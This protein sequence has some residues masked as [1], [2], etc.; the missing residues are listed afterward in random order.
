MKLRISIL[1]AMGLMVL[2][3]GCVST[4]ASRIKKEPQ[5]FAAFAP[6]IQVKIQ[7]GEIGIG[8]SRDMVRLALGLPRQVTI[9]TVESGEAE[10][11]TYTGSRYISSY[12]PLNTG[13]WYRDRAGRLNRSYDT[14]WVNRG[15]YEDYP[16]LKLEF[17]GDKL[18]AVERIK[19]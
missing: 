16:V 7:K 6:E 10:I 17:V 15:W 1:S 5:T 8:F 11:W 3:S 12:E 13:Y 18:K 14:M 2:V 19:R 9:R 4:P